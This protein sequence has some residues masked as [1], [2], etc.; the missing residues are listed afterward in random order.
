[1]SG[2]KRPASASFGTH[3][4]VKR[5]KSDA[6][7]GGG[8]NSIA[9]V[10]GS[11]QNGALIQSVPR[12]SGLQ[13]PVMEL[14]GHT[15]EV[16]ATRFDP[17]GQQIASGSMDKT[18]RGYSASLRHKREFN[19]F[20][21]LWRTYGDCK[22]FGTLNGHKG[23]ILDLRWSRDSRVLFSAS[24]DT[25]LASW[26]TETGE[27]IRRY[28]GHE[29][30]VNCLAVSNRGQEMF[31]SGSDDGSIGIWDAR[32]KECLDY[33]QSDFPITAVALAEA[34]N[35][36][37]TGSIDND[38]KVWDIRKKAV[39]YSL[40]GHTDTVTSL[41]VS[42]DHQSL[43]SYSHDST[44]QIWDIRPFAPINR[45]VRKFDGAPAGLEKNLI[46]ASWDPRGK[47]IA[48]GSGDRT[49]VVWD[50]DSGKMLY[51]LPGH[52]G[53]VN[54]V[55]FAPGNDPIIVSGCSDRTIILGELGGTE[56]AQVMI[57]NNPGVEGLKSENLHR[58]WGGRNLELEGMLK[59]TID[60]IITEEMA[61]TR[62]AYDDGLSRCYGIK[63]P[64][65]TP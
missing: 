27:R 4:V 20:S 37:Y 22:N 49:T 52:K 34:G 48:A 62:L 41:E 33:I 7:I 38:I 16:Y 57:P 9:V 40:I 45:H 25:T 58:G 1:M 12:T 5:Q 36:I 30:L 23:A 3:Q 28:Q 14:S 10:N 46:R 32:A 17:S 61:R 56:F 59:V 50:V 31:I 60:E 8:S 63:T 51:K 55:R 47:R 15:G 43:L 64:K 42:P 11:A 44:A 21:E 39:A 53:T 26:D 54:D 6:S 24:A 19:R 29:E 65:D 18:I 2:E 13:A 35:E